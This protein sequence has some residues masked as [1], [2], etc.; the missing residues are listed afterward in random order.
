MTQKNNAAIENFIKKVRLAQT[1]K[2]KDIRITIEEAQDLVAS[3]ALINNQSDILLELVEKLNAIMAESKK[4]NQVM[5][6]G[7]TSDGIDGGGF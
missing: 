6:Q 1:A 3:I 5:R 7:S 2:S 4:A